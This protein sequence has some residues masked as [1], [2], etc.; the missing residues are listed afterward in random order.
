MSRAA[1][2]YLGGIVRIG[3]AADKSVIKIHLNNRLTVNVLPLVNIYLF[4]KGVDKL[5]VKLGNTAVVFNQLGEFLGIC[6]V[7]AI[8]LRSNAKVSATPE[9]KTQT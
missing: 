5:I 3:I 6:P 2:V 1:S 9:I 8:F 4:N 7:V